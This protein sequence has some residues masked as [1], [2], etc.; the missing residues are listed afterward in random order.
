[1]LTNRVYPTRQNEKLARLRPALHDFV[2]Q[3][4]G[5]TNHS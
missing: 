5:L 1:L 4:L 3:G 2:V